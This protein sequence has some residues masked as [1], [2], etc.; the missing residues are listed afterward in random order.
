MRPFS[1]WTRPQRRGLLIVFAL[2]FFGHIAVY[3]FTK[4][5]AEQH[6][7]TPLPDAV[8]AQRDSLLALKPPTDTL[9]PFNP[10]YMSAYHAYRLGLPKWIPDSIQKRVGRRQYFSSQN[11][12]R[13]FLGLSDSIWVAI[14]PYIKLP[15]FAPV[16]RKTNTPKLKLQLNFANLEQLQQVYGVGPVLAERI[17]DMRTAL[18]GF[19]NQSQLDDVW[20]LQQETI[21]RLWRM[22]S[23]D[24]VPVI[25]PI[26]INTATIDELAANYYISYG[27]AARMVAYRSRHGQIDDLHQMAHILEIDSVRIAR[28]AL[29]LNTK[30]LLE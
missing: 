24:S 28:I 10:N 19:L 26:N 27:L 1:R 11:E 12:V 23:L 7:R 4:K 2:S 6:M 30:K 18:G 17:V 21:V 29:Y 13:R 25:K 5:S 22:F 16:K 20:G 3:K 14:A 15:E 8:V 9:Y